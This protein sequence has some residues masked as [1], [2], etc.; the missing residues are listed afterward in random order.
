M[1]QSNPHAESNYT[2][3][4]QEQLFLLPL[5]VIVTSIILPSYTLTAGVR[6]GR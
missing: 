1:T 3:L 2:G 6:D 5:Q 4:S